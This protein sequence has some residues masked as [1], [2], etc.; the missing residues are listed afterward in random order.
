MVDKPEFD[1]EAAHK[2]F[3][4][5]CF[6]LSWELIDKK[7]RTPQEDEEM[8][9]TNQVSLWHWTKRPDCT[10]KHL[11]IGY[12]Q[13][14]RIY[15][16]INQPD[17]AR[18]YGKMCLEYSANQAPFFKAYAYEALARAEMIAG[19]SSQM[20]TYLEQARTL[21]KEVDD[22]ISRKMLMDDLATIK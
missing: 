22:E 4:A 16:I 21:T 13:S 11:S 18:R 20:N 12:W 14:A 10:E 15:A 9:R 19:N 5:H 2:Y 3:S 7:N 6:N 17:N 8:I 1:I